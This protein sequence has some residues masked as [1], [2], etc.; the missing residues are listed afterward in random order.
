MVIKTSSRAQIDRLLIDLASDR[1]VVRETAV[2]RL[3][4]LGARAVERLEALAAAL[5]AAAG[6]RAAALRTLEAIGDPRSLDVILRALGDADATVAAAAAGAARAFLRGPRGATVV[7]RLTSI[8]VDP[9][10]AEATRLSAIR[11]L[12]NLGAPTVEPLYRVLAG[13]AN[14]AIAA[15]AVRH[16]RA[17][18]DTDGTG[19]LAGAIEGELPEDPQSVRQAVA[20]E[21]PDLPL[22]LLHTLVERVRKR[23]QAASGARGREW[24]TVRG[25]VHAALASRGSRVALYDLRETI[26]ASREPLPVDFLVALRDIGDPSCLEEV[27]AAHAHSSDE[28]WRRQLAEA[29]H[30][31]VTREH[32]TARHAAMKRTLKRFPEMW[33]SEFGIR[34]SSS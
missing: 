29:F 9:E 27:A 10:L 23:E 17:V 33:N 18:Q 13:D 5:E 14:A 12:S 15:I 8:A 32:L 1:D 2:T 16:G 31:I 22:P 6:T 3:T 4:V 19:W 34:N 21:G 28:W 24:M 7:D 30:A 11:T 26:A 20:A 25:A